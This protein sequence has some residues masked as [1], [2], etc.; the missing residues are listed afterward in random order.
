[1]SNWSKKYSLALD[2]FRAEYMLAIES[3][4]K[5]D[6][7]AN[8]CFIFISILLTAFFSALFSVFSTPFFFDH[9]S[10]YVFSTILVVLLLV[11]IFFV[12]LFLIKFIE[13]I[14]LVENK[15]VFISSEDVSSH[16]DGCFASYQKAWLDDFNAIIEYNKTVL[17]KKDKLIL[18][19][20]KL[21]S[22]LS[23][24]LVFTLCFLLIFKAVSVEMTKKN[25]SSVAQPDAPK[26]NV[27]GTA[28]PAPKA[29]QGSTP[30]AN[31]YTFVMDGVGSSSRPLTSEEVKKHKK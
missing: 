21:A 18:K 20:F 12:F 1:M 22:Y 27:S 6:E 14:Y 29:S 23:F 17:E 16:V 15:R 19:L 28:S 10:F 11:V 7:K 3:F 8:R 31:R 24:L 5:K 30:A 26:K 4:P 9:P 25:E 2:I 13:S